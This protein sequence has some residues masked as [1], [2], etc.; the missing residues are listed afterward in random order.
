MSERALR[1]HRSYGNQ[2][3]HERL[4]RL[5]Y[6]AFFGVESAGTSVGKR[7]HDRPKLLLVSPA[8]RSGMSEPGEGK[9]RHATGNAGTQPK[10]AGG[11]GDDAPASDAPGVVASAWEKPSLNKLG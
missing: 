10:S 4:R 1:L 3:M 2:D 5:L 6:E 8:W 7:Q 9:A 11:E